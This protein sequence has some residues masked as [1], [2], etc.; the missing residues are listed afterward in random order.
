TIY[1]VDAPAFGDYLAQPY[2]RA[3]KAI[4][5]KSG[6]RY[7]ISTAGTFGKDLLPRVA[8]ALGAGMVAECVGL[9][10]SGAQALFRRP[11]YAGNVIATVRATTDKAVISVRTAEFDTAEATG[12]QSAV[13]AV[14]VDAGA[15]AARYVS[16]DATESE[17][18]ELTEAD[19]VVAGGRGLK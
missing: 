2:T 11:M 12:G 3:A 1:T 17:R 18:P 5:D 8:A 10:G 16:F 7:V 19:V 15:V 13:E 4:A 9:A 6:A 14:A